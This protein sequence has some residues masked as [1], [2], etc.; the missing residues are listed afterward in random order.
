V[1]LVHARLRSPHRPSAGD[2]EAAT[3]IAHYTAQKL[4]SRWGHTASGSDH[5]DKSARVT[6][7]CAHDVRVDSGQSQ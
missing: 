1:A 5:I 2:V 4:T 7:P 3:A 6:A